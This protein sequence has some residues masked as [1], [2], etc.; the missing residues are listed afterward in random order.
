MRSAY[1]VV[2]YRLV[3]EPVGWIVASASAAALVVVDEP[4]VAVA[5][6]VAFLPAVVDVGAVAAAAAAAVADSLAALHWFWTFLGQGSERAV[7]AFR[8]VEVR[9]IHPPSCSSTHIRLVCAA[10]RESHPTPQSYRS[11]SQTTL[12]LY[13]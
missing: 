4:D 9:H 12:V 6:A 11:A 13:Y 5:A 3:A 10:H 8:A 7:Q 1:V 2:V